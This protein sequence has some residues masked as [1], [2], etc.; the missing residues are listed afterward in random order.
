MTTSQP[1]QPTPAPLSQPH[2]EW[3]T[4]IRYQA[5]QADDQSRQ[6]PP[7]ATLAINGLQ[8]GVEAMLNLVCEHH[9]IAPKNA[10]FLN[11]FDAVAKQ[12]PALTH[13]RAPLSGLNK[14]RVGFKHYGNALDQRTIEQRRG[15]AMDFL[16]DASD[17]CLRQ[18]FEAI[19]MVSLVRDESARMH[20]ETASAESAMGD[21]QEAAREL[22]LAFDRLVAD[23]EQRKI[24]YPGKTLFT[25]Q[26]SVFLP[27]EMHAVKGSE[28]GKY[29][30]RWMTELDERTRLLALRI[31]LRHH[32]VF[33]AYCPKPFYGTGGGHTFVTGADQVRLDD[34]AFQRC[35]LFVVET[36]LTLGAEDY[37][38][39]APAL[40]HEQR[41]HGRQ[42]AH[43]SDQT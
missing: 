21:R 9:S 5:R 26:P 33:N 23:Y 13:H 43:G 17:L 27:D 38:F 11:V 7:L 36:A 31:D 20:L 39:N 15:N 14:A 10:E 19:S 3:L 22:R 24:K 18:D 42:P 16:R 29:V 8:D 6:P 34:D 1:A 25:T 12:F 35:L 30:L 4:L 40:R 28:L 2:V 37:D 32:A 41:L